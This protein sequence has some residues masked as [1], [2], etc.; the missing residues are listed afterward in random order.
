M[1]KEKCSKC[2]KE[3]K[4]EEFHKSKRS[5][6]GSQYYCKECKS[7]IGKDLYLSKKGQW[8]YYITIDD[9]IRWVGSTKNLYSRINKHKNG[10]TRGNIVYEAKERGINLDNKKLKIYACDIKKMGLNLTKSD[11]VHYEHI[12]IRR[13]K[14]KKTL[15]NT[16]TEASFELRDRYIDEIPIDKFRFRLHQEISIKQK[17]N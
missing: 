5:R 3:K 6:K 17:V 8:L 13:L 16:R 1:N 12:L 7:K 2:N 10:M 4:S 9:C 11:L 15:F 14:F